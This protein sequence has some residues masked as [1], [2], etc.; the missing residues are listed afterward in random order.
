[1][2]PLFP[3]F[4][5]R[6]LP[7]M[8]LAE[9]AA[10]PNKDWAPVILQVGAIEQHGP[11]LPVA[12]D[13]LLGQIWLTLSLP[14][15]PTDV[16][17]YVAPPITIGKSNEHL[18]FPGTLFIS[19]DTLR[20][21]LMSMAM[22]LHRW[23]FRHI[24]VLNSHG[25]NVAVINYTMDELR[26]DPGLRV[27]ILR[28]AFDLNLPPQEATYGFHA[29]EAE[30]SWLLAAAPELVD[31]KQAVCEYPARVEDPGELRPEFAPATFAWIT[32]D[33]SRSGIMGDAPAATAEK[34][35]AWL[36]GGAERYARAITDAARLAR[37]E[38]GRPAN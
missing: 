33:L 9:I 4:R 17:C 29:N 6:Y 37:G 5:D 3:A 21:L 30:T 26:A 19:K 7:A 35:R 32:K 15:L 12:V 18:G 2:S 14:L 34:G 8:S 27:S 1:M 38:V 20:E 31:M 16:P 11:H 23:G 10:L 24:A 28:G 13:S 36:K 25:G 22:Q